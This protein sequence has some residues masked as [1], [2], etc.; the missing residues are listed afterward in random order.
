M[1][2][3]LRSS[4]SIGMVLKDSELVG[5]EMGFIWLSGI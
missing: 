5:M 4:A 3:A 2:S 1:F